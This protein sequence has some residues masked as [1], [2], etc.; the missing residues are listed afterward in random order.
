MDRLRTLV[1]RESRRVGLTRQ[2][3][4]LEMAEVTKFSASFFSKIDRK[5]PVD[6]PTSLD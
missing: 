4:G 1:L 3:R 5:L 6:S 2:K